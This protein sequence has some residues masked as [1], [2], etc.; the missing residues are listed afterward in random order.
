MSLKRLM[1]FWACAGAFAALGLIP[2]LMALHPEQLAR[3]PV[4]PAVF[5][6]A[7]FAQW[8]VLL[9]LLTWA[10]LRLGRA[11]GLGSPIACSLLYR[12]H[13]PESPLP[14]R[15]LTIAAFAGGLTGAALLVLDR[16]F[17]PFMPATTLPVPAAT[18]PWTRFIACF[19]GGI[20]EEL[21]CRLFL[22]TLLVW[23]CRRLVARTDAP[24]RPWMAWTGVI[25]AAILFGL[26]HLPATAA[27]WPLTTLV[28][29]RTLLLN[30]AGGIVFGWLYWRRGLEHAMLAHFA[31]DIVLHVA[32]GA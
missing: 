29:A 12:R 11:N 14:R 2:Y 19:Y 32:G 22:M 17:Q 8:F 21:I 18:G 5:V 4:S 30:G 7:Q 31:A 28:V 20:T 27:V 26:A 16:A 15:T 24:P 6:L 1:M 13:A 23:L 25:G 9:I 10:G 3:I